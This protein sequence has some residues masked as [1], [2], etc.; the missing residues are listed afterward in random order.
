MMFG[1]QSVGPVALPSTAATLT[2][3]SS[4]P[5]A[6]RGTTIVNAL[7]PKYASAVPTTP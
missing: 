4:P 1:T 6:D 2:E 3:P 5:S 7:V